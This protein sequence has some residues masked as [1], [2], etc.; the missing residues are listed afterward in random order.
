M[1][2]KLWKI[3]RYLDF[4]E[5]RRALLANGTNAFP[6]DL[7]HGEMIESEAE[8]G[9]KPAS[10]IRSPTSKEPSTRKKSWPSKQ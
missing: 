4:L 1:D 8:S 3:D 5:A 10:N 2:E 6:R 9:T 7:L